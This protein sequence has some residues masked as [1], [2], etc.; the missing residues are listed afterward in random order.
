MN[1]DIHTNK[2]HYV[3]FLA[4][5]SKQMLLIW[6]VSDFISFVSLMILPSVCELGMSLRTLELNHLAFFSSLKIGNNA[7]I[8]SFLKVAYGRIGRCE[9][10][11]DC[12]L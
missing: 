10:I 11:S 6:T 8:N 12:S 7:R 3:I 4:K 2:I 9:I 5:E 1:L